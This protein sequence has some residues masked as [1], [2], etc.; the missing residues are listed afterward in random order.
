MA[1]EYL[2]DH[3]STPKDFMKI[4]AM[5]QGIDMK[6]FDLFSAKPMS[7][8]LKEIQE[9]EAILKYNPLTAR[10]ER[11]ARSVRTRIYEFQQQKIW[12]EVARRYPNGQVRPKKKTF[13]TSETLKLNEVGMKGV[14]AGA[15]RCSIEEMMP[16][17]KRI[18]YRPA[19]EDLTPQIELD[20]TLTEGLDQHDSSVYEGVFSVVKT[21]SVDL[22]LDFHNPGISLGEEI[23]IL[24]DHD[25]REAVND[26]WVETYLR[27]EPYE[28]PEKRVA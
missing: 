26:D 6:N 7:K 25:G 3:R 15:V 11:H 12:L 28:L 22:Y 16:V 14:L 13:T 20:G 17:W 4:L 27:P 1:D 2:V 5:G 18:G 10:V 21:Y 23:I 24:K 19:H 8:L 9:Q